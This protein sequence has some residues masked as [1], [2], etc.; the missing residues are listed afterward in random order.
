MG[1]RNARVNVHGRRL[2]VHRVR[3]LGWPVAHAAKAM[4]ILRQCAHRWLARFDAEGD[5]GLEDRSSR[6]HSSPTRTPA[7]VEER[8]VAARRE[9]RVGTDR[10]ADATGVVARFDRRLFAGVAGGK[11]R[12]GWWCTH[13][14]DP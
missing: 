7:P 2:I 12:F 14:R 4:G 9:L 5:A 6:P 13:P 1:H 10:L 8:L 3:V 11:R